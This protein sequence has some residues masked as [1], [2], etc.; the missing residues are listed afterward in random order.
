MLDFFRKLTILDFLFCK[1]ISCHVWLSCYYSLLR[2]EFS[3][4][5]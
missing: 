5:S 1:K 3:M 2:M 4:R